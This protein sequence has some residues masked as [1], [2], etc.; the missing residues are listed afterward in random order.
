MGE[1]CVGM[2]KAEKRIK[3]YSA[4]MK[5][6]DETSYYKFSQIFCHLVFLTLEMFYL[7]LC[8]SALSFF[9]V[10]RHDKNL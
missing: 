3:M 8:L 2:R 7:E 4:N 6:R 9:S 5:R 10:Q 1:I